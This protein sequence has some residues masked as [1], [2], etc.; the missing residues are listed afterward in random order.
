MFC[1]EAV[2]VKGSK[3]GAFSCLEGSRICIH[4]KMLRAVAKKSFTRISLDVLW[5]MCRVVAWISNK[6]GTKC[7]SHPS[8]STSVYLPLASVGHILVSLQVTCHCFSN[9]FILR[10]R[11]ILHHY[12]SKATLN[13]CI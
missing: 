6:Q 4:F 9:V 1:W 10:T 13:V 12:G 8:T 7:K 2:K 3:E 11:E 5:Q